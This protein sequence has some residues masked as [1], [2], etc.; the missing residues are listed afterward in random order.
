MTQTGSGP[1]TQAF[2]AEAFRRTC[3]DLAGRLA[4]IPPESPDALAIVMKFVDRVIRA[5]EG[6]TLTATRAYA[7]YANWSTALNVAPMPFAIFN[8]NLR[9]FLLAYGADRITRV[10]SCETCDTWHGIAL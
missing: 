8:A 2:D 3:D 5:E 10:Q 4:D 6:G 9:Q 1:F 7:S